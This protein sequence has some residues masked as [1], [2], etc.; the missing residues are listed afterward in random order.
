[1]TPEIDSWKQIYLV[2]LDDYPNEDTSAIKVHYSRL[3]ENHL[4]QIIG[5]E[6]A[7]WLELFEDDF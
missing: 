5:H 3:S 2:Q 6:L 7:H 1:M 4:L